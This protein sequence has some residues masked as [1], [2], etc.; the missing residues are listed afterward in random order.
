MKLIFNSSPIFETTIKFTRILFTRLV[1]INSLLFFS[2]LAT[3]QGRPFSICPEK[4]KCGVLNTSGSWIIEP[5]VGFEITSIIGAGYAEGDMKIKQDGR[6]GIMDATG[7]I[8]IPAIYEDVLGTSINGL[9]AVKK[10]GKYGYINK[11][12]VYVIPAM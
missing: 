5:K 2:T 6:I 9:T 7:K 10:N 11:Q 3:A 12:G 8:K 4:N 1:I